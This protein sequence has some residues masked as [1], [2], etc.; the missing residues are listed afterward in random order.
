M[1]GG[2]GT[3]RVWSTIEKRSERAL[4]RE[5]QARERETERTEP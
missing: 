2:Y 5:E 3:E 1:G 4:C